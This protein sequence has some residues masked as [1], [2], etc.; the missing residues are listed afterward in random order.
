[1]KK[2]NIS[3]HTYSEQPTSRHRPG[4]WSCPWSGRR[5]PRT[6]LPRQPGSP[7]VGPDIEPERERGSSCRWPSA[8]PVW[9][10]TKCWRAH[11]LLS[12]EA[13]R[14]L[15]RW[16]MISLQSLPWDL[17]SYLLLP[18]QQVKGANSDFQ[19]M[20]VSHYSNTNQVGQCYP[21][22]L[23]VSFIASGSANA[24]LTVRLEE[25]APLVEELR[26]VGEV[27]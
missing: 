1:M 2:Y 8:T 25:L 19:K 16:P 7:E 11:A 17:V 22:P 5:Q 4:L 18:L 9:K 23:V 27:S 6:L 13:E 24:G 21:L 26:R 12:D 15:L 20:K 10:V 3:K 14:L